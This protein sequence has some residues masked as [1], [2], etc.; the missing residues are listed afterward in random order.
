[1]KKIV[2]PILVLLILVSAVCGVYVGYK[3]W[4]LSN[5]IFVE[6]AVYEKDAVFLDLRGTGVSLEH[7]ESLRR[8]LPYCE[9][10]YDL[11]FQGSFYPDDT[12]TLTITS[13]TEEEMLLLDLLPQLKTVEAAGC[14]DYAQLQALQK[15]HPDC[16]VHYTVTIQ[17]EAY[18]EDTTSLSIPAG[19]TD[20]S[21]LMENLQW[22]PQ[23]YSVYLEQPQAAPE[24]LR[25]LMEM[26]PD[27]S[28][29]WEKDALGETYSSDITEIDLSGRTDLTLEQV[30]EELAYFPNLE[31]VDMSFCG[32]DNET[33]A[34]FRE[35]MRDQYKVVW[36][37]KIYGLK[38]RTDDTYFM[39]V[40]HDVKVADYQLHQLI[41]CEDML[42]VDVGHMPIRKLDWVTGMPHLKY[43]IV[44]DGPLMYIEPL[45]TCKELIYLELFMTKVSD[46][47]PLLGCTALQDLNVAMTNGD[48]MVFKDMPWLKNLWINRLGV[49][50]AEHEEI[51][52]ALPDTHIESEHGLPTGN[53]WRKLQNYF[54]MRDLLGMGYNAW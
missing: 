8:Q 39:P 30:A 23:V 18:P 21:E 17:G 43:L 37:M 36:T 41:Y 49:S 54:D 33:M 20:V 32:F 52:A 51:Q 53:G 6:D 14:R 50:R 28:F 40:K 42:C 5:H 24:T 13:L 46:F 26:Y 45:S 44:A 7:Y 19:L 48:P 47:T 1:M 22:L 2:I 25:E 34:A 29:F 9:I 31:K 27:I 11:P 35:E 15:R 12:Q 3:I 4:H 16:E 10:R 38:V